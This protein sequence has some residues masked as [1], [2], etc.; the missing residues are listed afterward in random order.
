M[1]YFQTDSHGQ[2]RLNAER[3]ARDLCEA[4]G[5]GGYESEDFISAARIYIAPL[6]L[7]LRQGYGA[8]VKRVTISSGI[9]DSEIHRRAY[10]RRSNFKFPEVTVD[11]D[12]PMAALA[13]DIR[14]RVIDASAGPLAA[15]LDA[16]KQATELASN[17]RQHAERIATAF[18]TASVKIGDD[19]QTEAGF[20][21]NHNGVY[22]SG[23]INS[24]GA[25]YVDRLG[26]IPPEKL[27]AILAVLTS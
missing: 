13:K 17:V 9:A 8:Q 11:P 5:A 4:L 24:S 1:S 6:R 16:E 19:T 10:S 15:M 25:L 21:L 26:T 23:R 27:N 7:Y 3:F 14:K 12:R 22:L 2:I 18:P 20:Y